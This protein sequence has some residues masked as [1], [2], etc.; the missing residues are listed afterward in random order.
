MAD[1]EVWRLQLQRTV[2]VRDKAEGGVLSK[3]QVGKESQP[4]NWEKRGGH[5]QLLIVH[6]FQVF[7]KI[8]FLYACNAPFEFLS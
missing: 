2:D 5:P 4:Q 3:S 7:P 8:P 6:L 1:K